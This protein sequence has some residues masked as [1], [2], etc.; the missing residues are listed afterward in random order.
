L[1]LP[2]AFGLVAFAVLFTFLNAIVLCVRIRE[3]DAALH[4]PRG[5]VER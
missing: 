1:L 4:E 5:L 3:E 2:L